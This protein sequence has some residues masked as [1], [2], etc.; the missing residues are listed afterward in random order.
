MIY[1]YKK[2]VIL[3]NSEAHVTSPSLRMAYSLR[4]RAVAT[5]SGFIVSD[6]G[7]IVTNAHVVA[8][9]N[10]VKV[11]LRNGESYD[12]KIT[13]IDERSDIALLKINSPV[14]ACVLYLIL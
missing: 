4:E 2:A 8:D 9:K 6:D 1:W 13:D 10:R 5:G 7:L 14:G 12:A 11:E 3:C